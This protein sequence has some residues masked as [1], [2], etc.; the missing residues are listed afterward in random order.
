VSALRTYLHHSY[1]GRRSFLN[2]WEG[3]LK[4]LSSPCTKKEDIKEIYEMIE[5][6][7]SENVE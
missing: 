2:S 1:Q 7:F 5:D 3:I 4:V 6:T